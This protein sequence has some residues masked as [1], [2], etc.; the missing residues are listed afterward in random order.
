[1]SPREVFQREI[2]ADELVAI[3]IARPKILQTTWMSVSSHHPPSDTANIV[4]RL[5]RQFA[6]RQRTGRA[7]AE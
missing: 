7:A 1:M 4:A 3:P 5:I 6:A 2:D